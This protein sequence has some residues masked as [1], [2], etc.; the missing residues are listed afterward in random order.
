MIAWSPVFRWSAMRVLLFLA[1]ALVPGCGYSTYVVPPAELQRLAQLP[2]ARRG[3]HVRVYTPGVVPVTT[4]MPPVAAVPVPPPAPQPTL[5]PPGPVANGEPTGDPA[6]PDVVYDPDPEP[7]QPAVVVAVDIA[8]PG[9][10][11]RARLAPARP[12]AIAGRPGVPTPSVGH[13]GPTSVARLPSS[14]PA[15][16]SAPAFHPGGGHVH[17]GGSGI[18]HSG[19]GGGGAA[20]GAL[21]GAVVLVGLIAAVAES[22]EAP[23]FDGWIRIS[24]E[25]SLHLAYQSG[26]TRD[27]RL[28][29][30]K[31]ADAIGVSSACLYSTGGNVERLENA[32]S[33]PQS[34]PAPRPV[35]PP[36]RVP[37]PNTPPVRPPSAPVAPPPEPARTAPP[38]SVAPADPFS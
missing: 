30:L 4:P 18:H 5:P 12:L 34:A 31:P 28:C 17:S 29:D 37:V 11:L 23:P 26:A 33:V 16:G 15:R 2:P 35:P 19:G 24:P 1:T 20:V 22:S 27:M 13:G 38:P 21:V 32:A 25:H 10:P 14:L 3:D 6:P 7:S 36:A 9:P 8:P